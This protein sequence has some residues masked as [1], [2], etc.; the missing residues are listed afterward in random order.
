[1]IKISNLSKELGGRSVLSDLS[2][3]IHQ[4]SIVSIVGPNGSGKT[5]FLRCITGI[6]QYQGSVTFD[7][8][9]L[10]SNQRIVKPLFYLTPDLI[11]GADY[12]TVNEFITFQVKLY[13]PNIDIR[14]KDLLMELYGLAIYRNTLLKNCSHGTKKKV[15]IVT[16]SLVNTKYKIYDEPFNGLDP[17]FVSITK[18]V[19]KREREQGS[20]LIISNHNLNIVEEI[21]ENLI[22]LQDGKVVFS[23]A[24]EKMLSLLEDHSLEES[25]LKIIGIEQNTDEI[26]SK[27]Y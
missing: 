8:L 15:Q 13:Q 9:E 7:S 6:Y 19:F 10:K 18:K 16:S 27:I 5:T 26:L 11:Q 21:S 24:L 22:L 1:V 25:W 3:T 2:L 12:L 4:P 23:G 17:E 14:R 20:T